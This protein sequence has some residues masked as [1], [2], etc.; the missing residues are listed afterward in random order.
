MTVNKPPLVLFV[1]EIPE[2]VDFSDPDLPPGL[3]AKKIRAGIKAAMQ[4][5]SERGWQADLCLV[6]PDDRARAELERQLA[7]K[8][9]D[10]VVL[11]GGL[12]V[13]R[14]NLTLFETLVNTVC[15]FGCGASIAFNTQ[16]ENTADAAARW[17]RRA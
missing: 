4:Q 16:P 9:Y 11:G 14:K 7:E 6:E 13:P 2:S 12:R 10:C 8:S 17:L 1:G 3:D 15:K 5:M